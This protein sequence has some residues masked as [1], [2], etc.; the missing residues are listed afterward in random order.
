MKNFKKG[1]FSGLIIPL[2]SK[3]RGWARG[4]EIYQC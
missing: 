2:S 3:L 1:L 4:I